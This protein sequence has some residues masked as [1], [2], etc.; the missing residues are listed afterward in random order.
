M[1]PLTKTRIPRYMIP[2]ASAAVY[3]AAVGSIVGPGHSE[4]VLQTV[5]PM[6]CW[7]GTTDTGQSGCH[8]APTSLPCIDGATPDTGGF[9]PSDG[10]NCGF[11]RVWWFFVIPCGGQLAGAAC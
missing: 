7:A 1:N 2:V 11:S 8:K 4:P 6:A 3:L 5:T 10:T 9:R